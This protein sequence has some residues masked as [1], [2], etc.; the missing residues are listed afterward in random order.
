[1]LSRR[2]LARQ[3]GLADLSERRCD[4]VLVGLRR[5]LGADGI[6]TVRSRGWMLSP[7]AEDAATALLRADPA[8]HAWGFGRH[9]IGSNHYWYLRDPAGSFL[10]LFSDM[11]VIDDDE[12][13]ER[14]GRTP[15]GFEHVANSWG[16]AIPAEFI[17][18]VD[19]PELQ[20]AWAART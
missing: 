17:A 2:D 16:P 9:F 10:E 4:S 5:R 19:L 11:D 6:I 8:R 14:E 18:P 12:A 15:F 20:A 1:V 7:A 13:W 3:A